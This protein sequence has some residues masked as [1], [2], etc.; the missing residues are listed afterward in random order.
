MF[1]IILF[2]VF[3]Y[4][5]ISLAVIVGIYRLKTDSFSFSAHSSQFFESRRLFW[6][7][8]PWHFAI[9]LV[10]LAHLLAFLFP[11]AWGALAGKPIRLYLLEIT[12]LALGVMTVIGLAQLMLRRAGEPRV[13][14]VTT[15]MDWVVLV[16]LLAQV[17]SGVV[18]AWTLRWGSVWY[19]HT[20]TPWLWS[21]LQF[22]PQVEYIAA[23]PNIV[24]F[25]AFNAFL[26]IAVFPFSRL[27]HAATVPLG[28]LWRSPQLVLWN[29][30]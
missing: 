10:L 27:V 11:A 2:A 24:K 20:A 7:S 8:V 5:A 21:L 26:L 19:L 6:G 16:L 9:I 13:H 14:V 17:V 23:L 30:R 12:G 22:N 3:P 18:I 4:V 15:K 25:H 1:D 28:Y 29:R